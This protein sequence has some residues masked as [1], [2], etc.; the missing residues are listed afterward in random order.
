MKTRLRNFTCIGITGLFIAGM[1]WGCAGVGQKFDDW[2]SSV[3]DKLNSYRSENKEEYFIHKARW[4]RETL[5]DVTLWY[6]GNSKNRKKLADLNPYVNPD[7][8]PVGS[9]VVIPVSLLKTRE[10]LPKYFT[11]NFRKDQYKHTVRW[12]GESLSLIASWYTGS[13]KNWH[14]LAKINPRLNPNRIKGGQ[15]IL[16]PT[17]LLKTRVALPQKVAAKFTAD[18]FSY[19]VKKNDEKLKDIARWY[20]GNSANRK[21]LARANPDLNSHHLKKGNE[22]FIPKKLLKTREPIKAS[23]TAVSL[24]KP[25]VKPPMVQPKTAAA[26]E[27]AVQPKTAAAEDET[28]K[29]FGPKQH[30]KQ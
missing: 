17:A 13:S 23:K 18:Y 9:K 7:K 2:Q 30:P 19:K 24:S 26:E 5:A 16:I 22:V 3:R 25:A 28:V 4:S 1:C 21:L 11:G 27:P 6:T 20:T 12:P 10:P 29:L 8:I 14:K 15:V